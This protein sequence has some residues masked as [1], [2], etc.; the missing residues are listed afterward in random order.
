LTWHA[1]TPDELMAAEMVLAGIGLGLTISPI[2]TAVINEV[3]ESERGVSSALVII[4]RL[5]GMTIAISSLT[6]FALN[7]VA[8]LMDVFR[9]QLAPS[10]TS[11]QIQQQAVAAYFSS[12]IRAIDEMLVIG[13]VV[14]IVALIPAMFMRGSGRIAAD[15]AVGARRKLEGEL[16][17]R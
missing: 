4:L 7:R 6:T 17:S 9:S 15:E 3:G 12:A 10:L 2:G 8:Y 1:E 11:E 5:V 13:A 14:C 16:S